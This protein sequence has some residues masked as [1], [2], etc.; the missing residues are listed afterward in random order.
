M[1]DI[2]Q[3][4]LSEKAAEHDRAQ[5]EVT[6]RQAWWQTT[7]ALAGPA[8]DD[9]SGVTQVLEI[10][11]RILGQ[12]RRWLSRRRAL[13]LNFISLKL[14]EINALPPRLSMEYMNSHGDPVRAVAT[15]RDA[16]ARELSLR[17]FAAELGTQPQSW[18]REDEQGQRPVTPEQ[19]QARPVAEQ[20]QVIRQ[21]LA[22]PEVANEVFSENRSKADAMNA[23]RHDDQQKGFVLSPSQA[24]SASPVLSK[25]D[26]LV[27]LGNAK[28]ALRRASRLG[29]SLG[30]TGDEEVISDLGDV[31]TEAEQFRM[32]LTGMGVD[33]VI[34]KIMEGA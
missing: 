18:L 5:A 13:G 21:A 22:N 24:S 1:I 29:V 19:M 7:L 32:Y 9:K 27:F 3:A 11:E 17:D 14:D 2:E 28:D 12:T 25:L 10:A 16:E 33:E 20:A 23:I 30:L 26:V 8:V 4:A 31:E 6:W 15:L 34:A